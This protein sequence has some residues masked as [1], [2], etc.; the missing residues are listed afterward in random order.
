[1]K[2]GAGGSVTCGG[3]AVA[4]IGR[5]ALSVRGK[6]ASVV[7]VAGGKRDGDVENDRR[8]AAK[9][10]VACCERCAFARN[11]YQ[12]RTCGSDPT[13][14]MEDAWC[15]RQARASAPPGAIACCFRLI[16]APLCAPQKHRTCGFCAA[17][18]QNASSCCSPPLRAPHTA[19]P[20]ICTLHHRFRRIFLPSAVTS[21]YFTIFVVAKIAA[22]VKQRA[23]IEKW[24]IGGRMGGI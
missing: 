23:G 24:R 10:G 2:A 17:A 12:R 16:L 14:V 15:K 18:S 11:R 9:C 3:S 5:R 21:L 8:R 20:L 7:N 22:C 6:M 13:T 19:P 4:L 1:V